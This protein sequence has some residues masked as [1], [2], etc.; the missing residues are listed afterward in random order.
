MNNKKYYSI[1]EVSK[2]LNITHNQLRYLEKILSDITVYK[3][4]N[5][6][7]YTANDIKNFK[8][9]LI[10]NVENAQLTMPIELQ[11]H[12]RVAGDIIKLTSL[13][14]RPRMALVDEPDMLTSTYY[15]QSEHDM[16]SNQ[17]VVHE[18]LSEK[19]LDIV[20]PCFHEDDMPLFALAEEKCEDYLLKLNN[21]NLT[22]LPTAKLEDN[23]LLQIDNLIKN[24]QDLSLFIQQA[25]S[26]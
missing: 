1:N 15:L 26:S 20:D 14:K 4:R 8:S 13:T 25:L 2:I 7:Y 19:F 11:K 12:E 23:R 18:K 16:I 9:Y 22:P 21:E 3:I 24:F 10:E 17:E 5:R 6:K